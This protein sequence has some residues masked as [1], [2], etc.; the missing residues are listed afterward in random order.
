MSLPY[1]FVPFTTIYSAQVNANFQYVAIYDI[2]MG[3]YGSPPTSA[4][5]FTFNVVRTFTLPP[6]LSGSIFSFGT[7]PSAS[8]VLTIQQNGATIGTATWSASATY[9]TV[10]FSSLITFNP[11]DQLTILTPSN[12]N[13]AL[14]LAITLSGS[15]V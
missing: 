13:G 2:A 14:N 9:A 4:T 8:V 3:Y 5:L 10:S 1:T 15:R 11:G 12:L 7:A 6:A